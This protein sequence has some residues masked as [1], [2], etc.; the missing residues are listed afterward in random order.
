MT[1]T[2]DIAEVIDD[3]NTED[4]G[5][6][7]VFKGEIIVVTGLDTYKGCVNCGAKVLEMNG[8]LADCSKCGTKMKISRCRQQSVENIVLKDIEEKYYRV[9]VFDDVL[10]QITDNGKPSL[11]DNCSI[12]E[13]L[14]SAPEQQYTINQQKMLFLVYLLA[15]K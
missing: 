13:Q 12:Y 2:E 14:L 3:V 4:S 5:R 10:Q 11:G 8:I 7:K 6:A 15:F 1:S 9:T